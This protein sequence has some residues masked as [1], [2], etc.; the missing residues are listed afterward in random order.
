MTEIETQNN[1]TEE[2]L[3]CL[4]NTLLQNM[5]FY[6]SHTFYERARG[7][8]SVYG[9]QKGRWGSMG[10]TKSAACGPQR[11]ST[12]QRALSSEA[13]PIDKRGGT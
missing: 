10:F 1:H 8:A 5:L 4:P 2:P 13:P 6:G 12:L 9:G 7:R 11:V 3:E